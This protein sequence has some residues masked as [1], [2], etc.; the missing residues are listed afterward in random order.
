EIRRRVSAVR[1]ARQTR[2]HPP[3]R[4]DRRD[5]P[6]RSEPLR[7]PPLIAGALSTLLKIA[8]RAS[9][10]V[11]KL[12]RA[13]SSHSRVAKKLSHIALSKQSPTAPIEGRTPASWQRMPKAIEVYWLPWSE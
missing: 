13:S 2:A 4:S 9:A 10:W 6:R 3:L 12:R 7:L 5:Q 8:I 1:D 11:L